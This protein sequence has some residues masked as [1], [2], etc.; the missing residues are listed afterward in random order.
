M[1]QQSK[2]QI[3][4]QLILIIG[5]GL[6]I[7]IQ[8]GMMYCMERL[9]FNRNTISVLV[10]AQKKFNIIC[11]LIIYLK[12]VLLQSIQTNSNDIL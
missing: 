1:I 12:K 2:M 9:L 8:I 5:G 10:E 6:E 3:Q 7:P 4:T 11:L